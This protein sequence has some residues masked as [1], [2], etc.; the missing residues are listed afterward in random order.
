MKNAAISLVLTFLLTILTAT[1]ATAA[2]FDRVVPS[3]SQAMQMQTPAPTGRIIV[4]FSDESQILVSQS[5]L[6]GADSK[7]LQRV[8][9]LIVESSHRGG[10]QRHFSASMEQIDQQRRSGENRIKRSLPNLNRYGVIDLSSRAGDRDHLLKVLKTILADPA[11]ETAFLEPRAVPASLGFDAFTGTF[12]APTIPQNQAQSEIR[13]DTPDFSASQGYLGSAPEGVNAWAVAEVPGAR[14]AGLHIVDVEGAWV[15]DHED[16]DAPFYN[17]GGMYPQQDWRDHGTAVLGVISALDNGFGV[18]G[19]TPDVAIGGVAVQSFSVSTAINLAWNAVEPGDAVVIELHAP[20]PNSSGEGQ[21]GYVP[22]EY[23][24]DNFDVILIASANDRIVCEAAGNGAENLDDA[25][26]G[27]LFDRDYRDSGAILVGAANRYGVPEWFTNY[28]QRV[29]LNGWGSMV[30][31]CAYGDLQGS[32]SHPETEFYTSY[33]SG[34]SSATPV[35]TGAVLALQ[36]IVKEGSETILGPVLMREILVQTGSPQSGSSHIGPRPDLLA[37]WNETQVGFGSLTGTITDAVSGLPVANA[38]LHLQDSSFEL[39]TGA[40][41]EY[42]ISYPVGP[43]VLEITSFFH[44][45]EFVNLDIIG[46]QTTVR[47]ISINPL[48]TVTV[49]GHVSSQDDAPLTGVRATVL[50][51]PLVPGEIAETGLFNIEGVPE[52]RQFKLLVDNAPFHGADVINV[53]ASAD[54]RGDQHLFFQLAGVE[55]DFELWWEAYADVAEIWT[56]GTP[57]TGPASGFSGEKCWGVGMDGEGYPDNMAARPVSPQFNLYGSTQAL[58]SFHYWSELE[59]GMDGV[60]LQVLYNGSWIDVQ[61]ETEYDYD[62][63]NALNAVPG[64][65]GDSD[66]WR[67]AVFDVLPYTDNYVQFRF[68]LGSDNSVSDGGFYMDDITL[69]MGDIITSVPMQSETAAAFAPRVS[70]YPNPFNPQTEI[71]WEITQPGKLVIEVFDARGSLVRRLHDGIVTATQGRQLF[72][73]HDDR[74]GKLA[75]GMYLVRVRDGGG[76]EKTSRVSLVK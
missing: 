36:G 76:M 50:D 53:L 56:W 39:V 4:K 35:V 21:D 57:A 44:E 13:S 30:T 27:S 8:S 25:V 1:S 43:V 66:G 55:S 24:Q 2:A 63:I 69:D 71:A 73:G 14:G 58:L 22:M 23:W 20:G 6:M 40:S 75:S 9:D 60:K 32:P 3:S 34:T 61:P 10:F 54:S 65:T 45:D 70:I 16:L 41:G 59:E 68:F 51:A 29:D 64:W 42:S 72:D 33:F 52:G 7:T 67:G 12:T 31:T 37:A 46:G 74:G 18:R 49:T 48:P 26:Y 15:W 11:V 47:N 62:R 19:I 28:S 5:G 17:P 38:T